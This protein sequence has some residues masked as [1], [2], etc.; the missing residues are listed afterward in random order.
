[1]PQSS[2]RSTRTSIKQRLR[3][4]QTMVVAGRAYHYWRRRGVRE[5]LPD[6]GTAAFWERYSQ[7][8]REVE[9]ARSTVD[10]PKRP[11]SGTI[12]ALVRDFRSSPEWW[13]ASK[14]AQAA[15]M[16][17]FERIRHLGAYAPSAV[18]RGHVL[19]LRDALANRPAAADRFVICLRRLFDFAIDREAADVNPCDKI[20]RLSDPQSH[21]RWSDEECKRFEAADLPEGVRVA[22]MLARYS[23]QRRIEIVSMGPAHYD[24]KGFA[25]EREHRIRKTKVEIYVPAHKTLRAFLRTIN[26][27]RTVY[28]INAYG[29]PFKEDSLSAAFERELKK[30]GM[31]HLTMHG[32]RHAAGSTLAELGCTDTEIA[33][34]LGHESLSSTA[35]YTKQASQR[36]RATRA[37]KKWEGKREK[38]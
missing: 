24:G 37:M 30:L 20:K 6:F 31:G 38:D 3:Y 5:R 27:G 32:L 2:T 35:V 12:A 36:R 17:T 4:V 21:I 8:L 9:A 18:K 29:R 13:P 22:Y 28:A 11:R 10:G 25:F 15:Y 19:R 23:G 7:L 16:L 34:I 26:D 14:R 33:A 1:M